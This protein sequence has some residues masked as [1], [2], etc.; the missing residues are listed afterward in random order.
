ME[1]RTVPNSLSRL[2]EDLG[3]ATSGVI[4][5][6]AYPFKVMSVP[7]APP[8]EVLKGLVVAL[9]QVVIGTRLYESLDEALFGKYLL[10]LLAARVRQTGVLTGKT[11]L[12]RWNTPGMV[13]P[14]VW[15][16]IL[17]QIGVVVNY[18]LGVRLEPKMTS[19]VNPLSAAELGRMWSW[20]KAAEGYGL[21]VTTSW[22]RE[23]SGDEQF[24]TFQCVNDV[25]CRHDNIASPTKALLSGL[26]LR[27]Q[28]QTVFVPRVMY[29]KCDEIEQYVTLLAQS[30]PAP[31]QVQR[32][33]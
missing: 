20:L 27:S 1:P 28:L 25:I 29:L 2:E 24:M 6:E 13:I 19:S 23:Q 21:Q 22:T 30:R 18:S 3:V 11:G 4:H 5:P 32:E 7:V 14:S 16:L 10:D 31:S 9:H 33:E 15:S 12:L 26:V 17:S 8:A